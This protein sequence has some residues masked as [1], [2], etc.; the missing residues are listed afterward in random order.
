MGTDRRIAWRRTI[1][2]V[3]TV[4]LISVGMPG[5]ETGAADTQSPAA[6]PG[7]TAPKTEKGALTTI[8]ADR[9]DVDSDI[10]SAEFSGNVRAIQENMIITADRIKIFFRGNGAGNAQLSAD[11]TTIERIVASDAVTI[12]VDDRIATADQAIYR[13][14]E[15][16]LVLSGGNPRVM[17]GEHSIT[18]TTITY[19]RT[20][21][22]ITVEGSSN[23]RV[24][25]VFYSEDNAGKVKE[26]DRTGSQ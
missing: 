17:M 3:L 20:D 24:N 6:T 4:I 8:T 23:Q 2:P 1:G 11:E 7:G 10:R 26:D 25:A 19:H 14:D 18:G 16:V 5:V 22:H 21:G 9:L 13:T 15:K 12:T